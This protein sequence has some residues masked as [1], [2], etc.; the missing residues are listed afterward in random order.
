M[1]I[2]VW[3]NKESKSKKYYKKEL[4]IYIIII[5]NQNF[6]KIIN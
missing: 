2:L 1:Y 3:Y 6:L 5:F 4:I